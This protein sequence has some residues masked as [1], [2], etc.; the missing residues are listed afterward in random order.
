MEA[1]LDAIG[2]LSAGRA[3]VATAGVLGAMKRGP[4]PGV[5]I[6]PNTASLG[7]RGGETGLSA[8]ADRTLDIAPNTLP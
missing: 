7:D 5:N 3:G 6:A 2:G 1:I 8:R 4:L